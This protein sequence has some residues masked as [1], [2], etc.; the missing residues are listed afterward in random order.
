[1]GESS[2]W[3]APDWLTNVYLAKVLKK[4]LQDDTIHIKS[5]ELKPATASGENYASVMT[6]IKISYKTAKLERLQTMSLI[7]KCAFEND[8]Y[9]DQLMGP[10]D[11]T[12]T[13]MRMYEKILPQIHSILSEVGERDQLVPNSL[14]VDYQKSGIIF[15]DLA[16]RNYRLA[17]RLKGFDRKH[18]LLVLSKLAKF[19]AAG[20]VLNERL[21]GALEHFDRGILN[22]H[23]RNLGLMYERQIAVCA[24]YAK[25][26]P[27]LGAYYY[28]KLLKLLP[29]AVEYATQSCVGRS[30]QMEFFTLCHGD[31]WI[32]NM[33]V[34]YNQFQQPED[35]LL[36]DFQFSNWASPV[37]D[38]Y[39][40]FTTSME[41]RFQMD[42]DA[43]AELVQF[44]HSLLSAMLMKMK[45]MGHIPT[46]HELWVELEK[47]KFLVVAYTLT[48]RAIAT[49]QACEDAEF[50]SLFDNSEKA[51][52]FQEMCYKGKDHQKLMQQLLPYFDQ[53]GL[54]DVQN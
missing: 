47:R 37:L 30:T 26:C 19:H 5:V 43:Q 40:F 23:V 24:E 27:T 52:R 25:N 6:R 10:Y 13:E 17:D 38:L 14:N 54:L 18:A 4:Y 2:C 53:R 22:K 50:R 46:L 3:Q 7:V 49:V 33:L 32:N 34:K 42:F 51:K 15:E 20:A 9:V 28:D 35:V 1:M 16:V 31:F 21:N 44:Y 41:P 29:Y 39:Y 45:Y 48:N 36:L 8:P 12:N 11:V